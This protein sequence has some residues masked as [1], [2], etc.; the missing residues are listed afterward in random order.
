M[1]NDVVAALVE[2]GL[3]PL[4]ALGLVWWLARRKRL[5]PAT[6]HEA[7]APTLVTLAVVALGDSVL[8][9]PAP[10]ALVAVLLG[11]MTTPTGQQDAPRRARWLLAPVAAV[12]LVALVHSTGRLVSLTR[13]A[14]NATW[15]DAEAA[16][17]A[18]P[19]DT[20]LRLELGRSLALAGRCD[21][22]APHLE[23][24][25]RELPWHDIPGC[26]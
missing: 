8:Q 16:L 1:T 7:W 10:Q 3:W 9:L 4:V 17:R 21:Q 18:D 23:R 5:A 11:A 13:R 22:A 26:P 2:R 24:A 20:M 15:A 6:H 19:G 14:H 25:R 12:L